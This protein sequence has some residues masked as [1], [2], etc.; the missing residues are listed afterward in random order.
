MNQ[1]TEEYV[2]YPL[3]KKDKIIRRLYQETIM[4]M[5]SN[6]N[7]L[8]VLPTGL[9]KTIIAVMLSAFRLNKYPKQKIVML[10]PTRPLVEQHY[11]FF[12][13]VL[14][15][16]EEKIEILTGSITPRLRAVKWDD[17][18]VVMMTPQVLQNDLITSRYSLEDVSLIIFDEAHRA[19]GDYAYTFISEKYQEETHNRL[20]LGLT[21]SPGG[22]ESK[23]DEVIRNLDIS[24]VEIRS[25]R[26]PDV[27]KYIQQVDVEW[28]KI[29]LPEK[30]LEIKRLLSKSLSGK[31]QILKKNN[32]LQ[33]KSIK[34]VSRLDL[35]KTQGAIRLEIGKYQTPPSELFLSSAVCAAS[36]RLS[37]SIELLETQ[38]IISIDEF[39]NRTKAKSKKPG[40][41]KAVQNLFYE[42]EIIQAIKLIKEL[43]EKG[44]E[45]PKSVEAL[46][47]IEEQ[48]TKNMDS[49]ILVF[50]Q[51]R[52]TVSSLVKIFSKN[53]IINVEKF[54]GQANRD[55]DKGLSQKKQIELL[56]RFR[57]GELNLLVATQVA[58]E[59]LDI[60][61]CDL[62]IF[63]D[64]VPSGVRFIQR[65]GRTGRR[66]AGKVIV[67]IA[68]GTRD[69]AY[70]WSAIRKEKAM[71]KALKKINL[72]KNDAEKASKDQMSLD[73]FS[74]SKSFQKE[75][76][77]ITIFVDHR[78]Q[79]SS[80]VKNLARLGDKLN[81]KQLFVGDY[82]VSSDTVIERKEVKDFVDSIVD[83]R[84]FEQCL[85]LKENYENPII[86]IEGETIF[87]LR[88]IHPLAING[89]ISSVV[90]GWKIP[91]LMVKNSEETAMLIHSL[92]R[93][94]QIESKKPVK[95][96]GKKKQDTLQ[97]TQEFIIAGFPGIN[98][99]IA[100]RLLEKFGSI[101]KIMT[102]TLEELTS[103]EGLGK[104]KASNLKRIIS[105]PYENID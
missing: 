32:F 41:S 7:T 102:A 2:S 104:V 77:E 85:K 3:I 25:D 46:K 65:R 87:G 24:H 22:D 9:G 58:E 94:E 92:A 33:S 49:R 64:S 95:I 59:G 81:I 61:E 72:G 26:S 39:F 91:I 68:K 28:K 80:V 19:I 55:K 16:P 5:A 62:V 21:A 105:S 74:R 66:T 99:T 12:K 52:D 57:N 13:S 103:V 40:S 20:V 48:L 37:H 83:N 45:H 47:I 42:K 78:E 84:L 1:E 50:T 17:A 44:I 53:A 4:G 73:S 38:G 30:F 79:A 6:K 15:I 11:S 97:N 31:L 101:E 23:I 89:A 93:K 51:Y 43:R 70:Y 69:E 8:V 27:S 98:V 18:T 36:L 90:L 56:K 100:R 82:V 76:N 60:P 86:V 29:D 63:Y 88:N 34:Y 54:I 96:R 35:L 71:K 10:A 14:D 67:L 75:D